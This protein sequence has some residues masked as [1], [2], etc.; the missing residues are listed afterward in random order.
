MFEAWWEA[1]CY[2]LQQKKLACD[3]WYYRVNAMSFQMYVTI[4]AYCP[5][6]DTKFR[7][8]D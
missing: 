8:W 7:W 2:L 4:L 5:R 6:L 1:L 3:P